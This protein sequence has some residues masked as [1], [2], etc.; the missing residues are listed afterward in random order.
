MVTL[1]SPKERPQGNKQSTPL[2]RASLVAPLV[3]NPPAI[4]ETWD[5]SLGWERSP[6]KGAGYPLQ[7]S[8]LDNS[9]D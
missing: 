2:F 6:G 8:G 1:L 5:R 3:K 7:Y 4:R 9:M